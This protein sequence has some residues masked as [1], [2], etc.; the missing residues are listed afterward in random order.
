VNKEDDQPLTLSDLPPEVWR[1]L[2]DEA[3][4]AS[5]PTDGA[6]GSSGPPAPPTVA[7]RGLPFPLVGVLEAHEWNLS[8]SLRFCERMLLEATLQ[9]ARGNQTHAARLLGITPRSVYNKIRKHNLH[10]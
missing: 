2:A 4:P 9:A 1:Q 7:G 8:R 10:G 5:G 6:D 3:H